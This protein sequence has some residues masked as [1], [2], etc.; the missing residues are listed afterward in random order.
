MVLG[1]KRKQPSLKGPRNIR[2]PAPGFDH[3]KLLQDLVA[4]IKKVG[5]RTALDYGVY[6]GIM[7]TSAARGD[8]IVKLIS[9]I[10]V[11]IQ[12]CPQLLFKPSDL[13]EAL[14]NAALQVEGLC[15][16][17]PA[18]PLSRW[19]ADQSE[20]LL[21]IFNHVRR[22]ALSKIRFGQATKKMDDESVAALSQLVA[23]VSNAEN[24]IVVHLAELPS[25]LLAEHE[26]E[27]AVQAD[28]A[29]DDGDLLK[30]TLECD[31]MP[32]S[33]KLLK[34]PAANVSSVAPSSINYHITL[35]A[36]QSYI[37]F[38]SSTD[39]ARKLLVGCSLKQSKQHA[40]VIKAIYQFLQQQ[41]LTKEQAVSLRNELIS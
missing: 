8:G 19:A 39:K 33:K 27:G 20:R 15:H 25:G 12:S 26:D 1:C 10:N 14:A 16:P 21:C 38:S 35:A 11:F 41:C 40:N 9:L 34:R 13:K 3:Q 5:T 2:V 22:I 7:V 24:G 18:M 6:K 4:H 29:E 30:Q 17:S 36:A 23:K 37:C 28:A 32:G 31:P